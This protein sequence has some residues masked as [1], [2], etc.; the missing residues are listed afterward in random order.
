MQSRILIA[1]IGNIFLGDDAFGCEVVQQLAA[2]S[3]PQNVRI[4]DFATRSLDLTFAL[5]D[6][7]DCVI[8]V[9]A[10]S[11]GAPPGS[12][13]LIEPDIEESLTTTEAHGM[14][15]ARVLAMARS[16]GARLNRVLV[17]GCEPATLEPTEDCERLSGVVREAVPRAVEMIESLVM[18]ACTNCQSL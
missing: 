18:E 17:V 14:D 1:G 3:Y 16:M 11:R 13:Y 12:L 6:P 10:A 9:D 4:A 15:L 5:L 2:R 8:L 7:Y